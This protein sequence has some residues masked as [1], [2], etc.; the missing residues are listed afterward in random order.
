MRTQ[1]SGLAVFASMARS[2]E[3]AETVLLSGGVASAASALRDFPDDEGVQV[4]PHIRLR[5][6]TFRKIIPIL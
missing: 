4:R 1:A 5:R 6:T 3:Y 2:A